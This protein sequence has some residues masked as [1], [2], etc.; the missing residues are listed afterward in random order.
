MRNVRASRRPPGGS[1][2][3]RLLERRTKGQVGHP[4]PHTP[5]HAWRVLDSIAGCSGINKNLVGQRICFFFKRLN[6]QGM[7]TLLALLLAHT[8]TNA[9]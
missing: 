7:R 9:R 2:Q 3:Y 5:H 8:Y 6:S 4:T 1:A